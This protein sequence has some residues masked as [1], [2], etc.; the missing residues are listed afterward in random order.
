MH[1]CRVSELFHARLCRPATNSS[2]MTGFPAPAERHSCGMVEE[3]GVLEGLFLCSLRALSSALHRHM[4]KLTGWLRAIRQ[5]SVAKLCGALSFV[6]GPRTNSTPS[7]PLR[8]DFFL[9]GGLDLAP[10]GQ[11]WDG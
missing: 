1:E 3:S 4:I 7:D 5:P 6:A 8:Q 9:S 11:L 10:R 2:E